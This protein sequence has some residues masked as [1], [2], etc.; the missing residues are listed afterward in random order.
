MFGKG[1][2]RAA[3][4]QV[5]CL[6][7]QGAAWHKTSFLLLRQGGD[8]RGGGQHKGAALPGGLGPKASQE[9][10]E[11]CRMACPVPTSSH[12]FWLGSAKRASTVKVDM[13][14]HVL[15]QQNLILGDI[16][17]LRFCKLAVQRGFANSTKSWLKLLT[18]YVGCGR[19]ASNRAGHP[20]GLGSGD[21]QGACSRVPSMLPGGGQRPDPICCGSRV[22]NGLKL[23]G[24]T[25]LRVHSHTATLVTENGTV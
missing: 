18:H 24:C 6:W 10:A 8:D 22:S 5:K 1:L 19:A 21:A 15:L 23:C 12:I 14:S 3:S 11:S 20:G 2:S 7:T 25:K 17:M 9:E 16:R 13:K 4:A